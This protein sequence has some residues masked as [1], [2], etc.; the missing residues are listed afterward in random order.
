MASVTLSKKVAC[1]RFSIRSLRRLLLLEEYAIRDSD[2][3]E[4]DTIVNK[5][6]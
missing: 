2:P 1:H 3:F 5:F 4:T 6:M